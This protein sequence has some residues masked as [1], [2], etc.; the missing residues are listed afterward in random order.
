MTPRIAIVYDRI[1]KFGGAEQVLLALRQ[2]FPHSDL[3]T[4]VFDPI[5]ASWVGEWKVHTSFLQHVPFAKRNHEKLALFMPIAFET[6]DL[7]RFDI[8]ITVTSEFAKGVLTRPGQLHICYCLTPTRYLWSHT[9]EYEGVH[10]SWLKRLF[11][12]KLREWDYIAGQ[13]PDVMVPI[14]KHVKNRIEK[15]YRRN[16]AEVMYPPVQLVDVI[17]SAERTHFLVVSR[18]VPYKKIELA[19]QASLQIR[20]PLVVVGT[21]SDEP[22]LKEE[23]GGSSLITFAGFV[24]DDTLDELYSTAIALICPQEEDFGIV[25][26]EAQMHG[27]PVVT[28]VHSGAVETIIP[29]KTG[30]TFDHQTADSLAM[31]LEDVKKREWNPE[32]L[33][34]HA[35]QF[36]ETAFILKMR[37][38]VQQAWEKHQRTVQ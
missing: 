4:S 37:T 8:I 21:G 27:V 15:Y 17:K 16:V 36:E 18:L 25:C 14:S 32:L 20:T 29:G 31:A 6:V 10:F 7:S 26:L 5:G 34:K 28:Y 30:L 38:Y 23:A 11:F 13:R 9:K 19:I 24:S 33:K 12:T 3:F 1:N 2:A 35:R 22:R